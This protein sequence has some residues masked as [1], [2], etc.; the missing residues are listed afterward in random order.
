MFICGGDFGVTVSKLS[1]S[2]RPKRFVQGILMK[3]FPGDFASLVVAAEG[4]TKQ[5][6]GKEIYKARS[7]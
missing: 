2:S 6:D 5:A 4:I 7:C 1:P 3:S